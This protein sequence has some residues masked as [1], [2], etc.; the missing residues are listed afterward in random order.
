MDRLDPARIRAIDEQM[1]CHI[2]DDWVMGSKEVCAE[3]G[4]GVGGSVVRQA[5][6]GSGAND[7]EAERT[8][9]S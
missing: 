6:W 2:N 1:Q 3:Y 4:G 7:I 9:S 5:V 8:P